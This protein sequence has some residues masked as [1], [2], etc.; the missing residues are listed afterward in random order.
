MEPT[1]DPTVSLAHNASMSCHPVGI[2]SHILTESLF[3]AA[4]PYLELQ[5]SSLTFKMVFRTFQGTRDHVTHM[6][7]NG[8]KNKQVPPQFGK[9]QS[10]A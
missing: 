10:G 1:A 3:M 6:F 8:D 5:A 9:F 4:C 7:V 2:N